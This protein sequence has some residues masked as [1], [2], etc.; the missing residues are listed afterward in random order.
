MCVNACSD[1]GQ[2][3][4]QKCSNQTPNNCGLPA[5]LVDFNPPKPSPS[6][7]LRWEM[8]E[9]EKKKEEGGEGEGKGEG[10]VK[11]SQSSGA[12]RRPEETVKMGRV[13][14]LKYV[15]HH[16]VHLCIGDE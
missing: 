9:R 13:Y 5:E 10:K 2:V 16:S 3:C 15:G 11:Q 8:D 7:K 6:K 4:H 14:V 1:C 12:V